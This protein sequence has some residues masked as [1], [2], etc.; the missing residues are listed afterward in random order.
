[1]EYRFKR[2]HT[3]ENYLENFILFLDS[4]PETRNPVKKFLQ[5]KVDIFCRRCKGHVEGCQHCNFTG[6]AEST[7]R[8]EAFVQNGHVY[9]SK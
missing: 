4:N 3:I 1:M 9:V 8:E 6:I 7:H 5:S 2:P